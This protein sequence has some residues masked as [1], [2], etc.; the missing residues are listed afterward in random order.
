[1][2]WHTDGYYNALEQPVKS[3]I[4]HCYQQAPVGGENQLLDPEIA[5]LRL[6]ERNPEFVRALMHPEAMT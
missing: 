5:Y 2:N 3:F 1:M 4:L 6:R